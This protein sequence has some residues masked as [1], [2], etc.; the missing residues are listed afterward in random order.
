MTSYFQDGSHDIILLTASSPPHLTSL[1]RCMRYTTWSIVTFVLV[2]IMNK[3]IC[4]V[5]LWFMI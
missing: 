5:R 2:I 4:N 1:A 3:K